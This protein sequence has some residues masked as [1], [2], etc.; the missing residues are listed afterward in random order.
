MVSQGGSIA[1]VGEE[2]ITV[3]MV[4][5]VRREGVV[6]LKSDLESDALHDAPFH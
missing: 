6:E 2:Q 3:F 4:G 5:Y 1:V